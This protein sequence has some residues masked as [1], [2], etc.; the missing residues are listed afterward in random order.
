MI[1]IFIFIILMFGNQEKSQFSLLNYF[2]GEYTVYTSNSSGPNS[3]DLGFCYM[4]SSP[5]SENVIGESVVLKNYEVGDVIKK[6][7]AKVVKTES[8]EDGTIVIYAITNLIQEKVQVSGENVNL[9]IATKDE[10]T[11]IGWPLIL[12]SY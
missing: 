10:I 5:V 11:V 3:V 7:N 12:G 6:L 1:V 4:N 8:L 9:Q 2:S